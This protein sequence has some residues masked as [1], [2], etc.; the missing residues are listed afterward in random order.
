MIL[1]KK[2]R[3]TKD[4]IYSKLFRLF[5]LILNN[6]ISFLSISYAEWAHKGLRDESIINLHMIS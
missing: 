1:D 3:L 5:L 2:N 6:M 4:D